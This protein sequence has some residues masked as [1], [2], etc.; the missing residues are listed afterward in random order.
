MPKVGFESGALLIPTPQTAKTFAAR[1]RQCLQEFEAQLK[2][3]ENFHIV[4]MMGGRAFSVEHIGVRGS[5]LVVVD[6][7]ADEPGRYRLLCHVDALQLMLQVIPKQPHE[8]R[9]RIGFLWDDPD[10]EEARSGDADAANLD[11]SASAAAES[12]GTGSPEAAPVP[13]SEPA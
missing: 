5:E 10:V 2:D 8:K 9:R 1:L 7:P 3:N 11:E 12:D 13:V 4:A 6:G